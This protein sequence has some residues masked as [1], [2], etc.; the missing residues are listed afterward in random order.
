[1]NIVNK[2]QVE[3]PSSFYVDSGMASKTIKRLGNFDKPNELLLKLQSLDA[4]SFNYFVKWEEN[5]SEGSIVKEAWIKRIVSLEDINSIS[6]DDIKN[7]D[8]DEKLRALEGE[9]HIRS[10]VAMMQSIGFRLRYLL[11]FNKPYPEN[12]NDKAF[13][14][15]FMDY[16]LEE[17]KFYYEFLSISRLKEYIKRYTGRP[18]KVRKGLKVAETYLEAYLS[19]T[20]S[21]FP[22][23]CDELIYDEDGIKVLIEYKKCTKKD[24]TQVE[25]Q[26]FERFLQSE[27]R[28]KYKRLNILREYIN[29]ITSN[30]VPLIN[31]LYSVEE[32]D[33]NIK[34]E[35][36]GVDLTIEDTLVFEANDV[37]KDNKERLLE[38]IRRM[39]IG[40][41][42]NEN[43][44]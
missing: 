37:P 11:I 1:M 42:K 33:K 9:E 43:A 22:G 44:D 7:S 10:S 12:I 13:V 23:D 28:L 3:I 30:T 14:G 27:D 36:I 38:Y 24:G 2:S 41:G 26:S 16:I 5:F 20:D 39:G 21:P 19:K 15:F 17:D 32:K 40:D 6:V 35:K 4:I 31:V 34:L 25:D 29:R 18:L 8:V